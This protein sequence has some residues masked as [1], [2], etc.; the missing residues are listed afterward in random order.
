MGLFLPL[1]GG[2][3]AL[4]IIVLFV[5]VVITFIIGLLGGSVAWL[6]GGRKTE[7][8]LNAWIAV[9]FLVMMGGLIWFIFSL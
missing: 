9:T 1:A 5:F 6:A 8:F 4:S 7:D 2:L 3:M